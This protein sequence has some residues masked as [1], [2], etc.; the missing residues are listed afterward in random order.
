[1]KVRPNQIMKLKILIINFCLLLTILSCNKEEAI[2]E[3]GKN[4]WASCEE[5]KL[6][7]F[8]DTESFNIGDTINVTIRNSCRLCEL[9]AFYTGL[10][11]FTEVDTLGIDVLLFGQRT[12]EN[13]STREYQISVKRDFLL[14]DVTRVELVGVCDS[15]IIKL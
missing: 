11:V 9:G 3:N 8:G 1:M 15:I 14:D 7:K 10:I 4:R 12:P 2:D 13:K 6:I 5:L